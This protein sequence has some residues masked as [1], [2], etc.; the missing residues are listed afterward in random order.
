MPAYD[1][2]GLV[3]F[4]GGRQ[5]SRARAL[6]QPHCV[7]TGR[8]PQ[9]HPSAGLGSMPAWCNE[10]CDHRWLLPSEGLRSLEEMGDP[11]G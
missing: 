5:G 11:G 7:L 8:V 6:S 10:Q 4:Y 3:G 2:Q 1:R 9:P